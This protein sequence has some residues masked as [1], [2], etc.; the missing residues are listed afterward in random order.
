MADKL[1]TIDAFIERNQSEL[2]QHV[3]PSE[4]RTF[5]TA[6]VEGDI[7]GERSLAGQKIILGCVVCSAMLAEIQ[8]SASLVG[9][10]VV[11]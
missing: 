2:H 5:Y 6:S 1:T 4:A 8:P 11:I 7:G 10:N 9:R 3:D